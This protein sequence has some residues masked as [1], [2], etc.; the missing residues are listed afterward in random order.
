MK[1]EKVINLDSVEI[2]QQ[3]PYPIMEKNQNQAS[4]FDNLARNYHHTFIKTVPV[5]S[6]NPDEFSFYQ[7]GVRFL[8]TPSKVICQGDTQMVEMEEEGDK[9]KVKIW[10]LDGTEYFMLPIIY[11][12]KFKMN[13]LVITYGQNESKESFQTCVTK[14]VDLGARI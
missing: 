14:Q 2:V 5:P 10:L 3:Y 12:Y 1:K 11:F 7:V 9:F 8:E 13:R 6:G 4:F